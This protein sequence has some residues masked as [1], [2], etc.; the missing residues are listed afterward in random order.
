M[1]SLIA[2][3]STCPNAERQGQPI[4]GYDVLIAG[5]ARGLGLIVVTNNLREF[6]RVEGL[7]A[8][9]WLAPV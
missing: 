5:H 3:G 1:I 9:D 4:G 6:S 2:P 8:E 7:R